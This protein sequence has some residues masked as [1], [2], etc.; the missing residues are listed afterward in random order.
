MR[1]IRCEVN[2]KVPM[3][4][5]TSSNF[6]VKNPVP[7]IA[8]IQRYLERPK[9]FPFSNIYGGGIRGGVSKERK[10]FVS[11]VSRLRK[12]ERMRLKGESRSQ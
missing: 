6:F 2:G 7:S 1:T 12:K 4:F 9:L 11:L 3:K 5:M 8:S 10:R